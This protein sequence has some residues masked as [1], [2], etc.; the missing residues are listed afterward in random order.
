M[1]ASDAIRD[2]LR[3]AGATDRASITDLVTATVRRH[4]ARHGLDLERMDA[5]HSLRY[6]RQLA[7][8]AGPRSNATLRAELELAA[9]LSQI[10]NEPILPQLALWNLASTGFVRDRWGGAESYAALIVIEGLCR[11]LQMPANIALVT[12]G[13]LHRERVAPLA[14]FLTSQSDD[15]LRAAARLLWMDLYGEPMLPITD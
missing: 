12:N 5:G 10:G 8:L 13:H 14:E 7:A 6:P 11:K 4:E 9:Y 15:K 3:A 2:E 1:L